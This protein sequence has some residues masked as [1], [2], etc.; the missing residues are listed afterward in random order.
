SPS[1]ALLAPQRSLGSAC[2]RRTL[3][4]RRRPLARPASPARSGGGTRTPRSGG[5]RPSFGCAS[6]GALPHSRHQIVR[7]IGCERLCVLD[8]VLGLPCK[9]VTP[10]EREQGGPGRRKPQPTDHSVST[11]AFALRRIGHI[12]KSL[13]IVDHLVR[14]LVN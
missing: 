7:K 10:H 11:A 9:E 14:K 6:G 5:L 12:G 13:G 3:S 4:G 1:V 8:R 2:R